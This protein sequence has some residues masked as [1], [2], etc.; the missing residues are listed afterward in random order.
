L[1]NPDQKQA[2]IH[3]N[4]W[5]V[6]STVAS[7]HNDIPISHQLP[8]IHDDSGFLFPLTLQDI[9][10]AGDSEFRVEYALECLLRHGHLR[11]A[12]VGKLLQTLRT[13]LQWGMISRYPDELD[14]LVREL[15]GVHRCNDGTMALAKVCACMLS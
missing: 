12:D 2:Q 7:R 14:A 13:L 15:P 11:A 5:T 9:L 10:D 4:P 3:K 6:A 1:A 8:P